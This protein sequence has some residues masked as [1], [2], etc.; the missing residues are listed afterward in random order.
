MIRK[1]IEADFKTIFEII[2]EAAEAYRGV[3]PEDQWYETEMIL[4][5]LNP[6]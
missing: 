1:C 3:I 6:R 4:Q 5:P 2:N